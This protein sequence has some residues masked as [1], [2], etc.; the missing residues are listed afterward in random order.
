MRLPNVCHGCHDILIMSTNRSD[1][2]MLNI[3]GTD[4]RCI[5]DRIRKNEAMNLLKKCRF[6]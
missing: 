1:I 5:I 6:D 4:Y 3:S 2:A